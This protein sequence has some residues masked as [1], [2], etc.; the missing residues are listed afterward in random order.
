LSVKVR[1]GLRIYLLANEFSPE[2]APAQAQ[3]DHCTTGAR[4]PVTHRSSQLT[5]MSFA[6]IAICFPV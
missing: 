1:A 3:D 2:G 6:S 5:G 4:R